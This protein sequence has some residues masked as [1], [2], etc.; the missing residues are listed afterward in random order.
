MFVG[1][2]RGMDPDDNESSLSI[3][4]MPLFDMGLN[5]PAIVATESPKL[6][7]HDFA[8]EVT[9]MHRVAVQP[10]LA[11][12]VR[13]VHSDS[14][15]HDSPNQK[16]DRKDGSDRRHS[17]VQHGSPT[18]RNAAGGLFQH[19]IC[20]RTIRTPDLPNTRLSPRRYP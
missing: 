16:E 5:V 20:L 17:L 9:Q 12:K 7:H 6:D 14:S 13:R 3:L 10:G 4:L 18:F 1:K 11:G 15:I 2:L 8:F 19:S